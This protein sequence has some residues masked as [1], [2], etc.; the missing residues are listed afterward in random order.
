VSDVYGKLKKISEHPRKFSQKAEYTIH[1]YFDTLRLS[2]NLFKIMEE[3]KSVVVGDGT[4]GKTCLL[5]CYTTD[6]YDDSYIP[7]IFDTYS[8]NILLDNKPISLGLW[9]TAGQSDY[10]RLR[11][12]S[13]PKTDVFL[14]CFSLIN[15][16]TLHS[17][18]NKWIPEINHYCPKATWI[19][20]GTK[21]DLRVDGDTDCVSETEGMQTA[22]DMGAAGYYE[23]SSR[24]GVGI[25]HVFDGAI[26]NALISKN[27]VLTQAR[28]KNSICS[29]M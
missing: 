26:R 21:S 29:I 1:L 28:K 6:K 24:T 5:I 14:V 4:V 3:I 10:D 13:Y 23:C 2:A 16:A 15:K 11:P 20:V 8:C 19:L 12:L 22:H 9:D 27:M 25:K 7:T 18:R 17:V